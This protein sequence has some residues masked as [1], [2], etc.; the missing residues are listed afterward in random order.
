MRSCLSLFVAVLTLALAGCAVTIATDPNRFN[1]EPQQLPNLHRPQAVTLKNA[2]KEDARPLVLKPAAGV[3][4]TID[5]R[6]LTD[7]AVAMLGRAL[8]KNGVT[9]P[10]QA[11]KEIALGVRVRNVH[12]RR[13]PF[14]MLTSVR[15]A[16]Y[17][18][19]GD[20]TKTYVEGDYTKSNFEV[21]FDGAVQDALNH[22]VTDEK[23]VAYLNH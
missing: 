14:A 10:P 2:V 19:F 17:V 4:W 22:L 7:T 1:V 15:V 9:V 20:G 13:V 12:N 21:A 6:K 11:D 5:Q 18:V 8:E 23:F 3:S 16:I